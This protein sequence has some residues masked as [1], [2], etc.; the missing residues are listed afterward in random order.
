[1]MMRRRDELTTAAS[2]CNKSLNAPPFSYCD[3]DGRERP[4]LFKFMRT[5]FGNEGALRR[6][7]IGSVHCSSAVANR[8]VAIL[9]YR[10]IGGVFE[11]SDGSTP[12]S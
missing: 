5:F 6:T 10:I 12:I 3:R 11:I 9:A 1:M 2:N 8:R 4:H 7:S